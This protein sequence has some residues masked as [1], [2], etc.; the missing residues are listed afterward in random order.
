MDFQLKLSTE[1]VEHADPGDALC[2]EPTM[3]VRTVFKLLKE[4]NRGCALICKDDQL[5]G[6]FTE[7]DAL[8]LMAE[9]AD[10]G[11]AIESHMASEPATLSASETVG[12]AITKMAFGGYR[13]LP[14][15]G[16]NGKPVG[17]LK[18]SNILHYLVAHFPTIVYTLPPDPHHS[19]QEREGA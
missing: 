19:T 17:L 18:A 16:A 8:K 10:L 15:V 5:V 3:S 13:R 6:I 2:V 1:T 7:R 14:I 9:G 4:Q 12:K 11:V